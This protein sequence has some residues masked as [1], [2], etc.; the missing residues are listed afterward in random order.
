MSGE[1][2]VGRTEPSAASGEGAVGRT[3]PSAVSGE[4]AVGRTGWPAVSAE[5]FSSVRIPEHTS[6]KTER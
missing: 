1:G 6:P 5:E 4:G 2:A 3:E